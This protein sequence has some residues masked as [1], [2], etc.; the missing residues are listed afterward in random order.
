MLVAK[1]YLDENELAAK[2]ILKVWED[3]AQINNLKNFSLAKFEFFLK[4]HKIRKFFKETF[5]GKFI[6]KKT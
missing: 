3:L 1:I 2:K 4:T 5:K 6:L